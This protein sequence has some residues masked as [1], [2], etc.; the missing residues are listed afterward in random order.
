VQGTIRFR[1]H[2]QGYLECEDDLFFDTK[3]QAMLL[4]LPAVMF[5]VN[6]PEYGEAAREMVRTGM[7]GVRRQAE[8]VIQELGFPDSRY[9]TAAKEGLERC[10]DALLQII[11]ILE[12]AEID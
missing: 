8:G 11:E 1:A 2:W 10:E 6:P 5:S 12:R 9:D 3:G 4:D 7:Q